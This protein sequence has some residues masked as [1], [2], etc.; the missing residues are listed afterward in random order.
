MRRKPKSSQLFIR[1]RIYMVLGSIAA[2]FLALVGRVAFI[3]VVD[4]KTLITQGDMR[5]VRTEKTQE[6]RG[7]IT[8]RNGNELAVSVAVRAV[9]ADPKRI[10]QTD[11]LAQTRKWK[12]LAE[13]LHL[14]PAELQQ[15][16]SNPKRRFV[17]L[18]RQVNPALG[19]FIQELN[20]P[21]VYLKP[22]S[23]RFYPAGEISAHLVGFT[24]IDDH[25]QEGVELAYDKW[26]TGQ[27]GERVVRK[28]RLGRTIEDLSVIKQQQSGHDIHLSLDQRI[29]T[30]A[31]REIKREVEASGATSGSVVVIDIH[32]G[33]VLAMA[34]SPSFNPNDRSQLQSYRYRNRAVTDAYEPGSTMKPFTVLTALEQ[35]KANRNTI[36]NNNPG[37]ISISGHKV[38]D[39]EVLG[40]MTL[41]KILERS[42]NIG[43][44]TLA[45]RTG[46]MPLLHTY[47][48]V[49]FGN[50]LGLGLDGETTGVIPQRRRWSD[51]ELATIAFG[52]GLTVSPLQLAHAYA[53]LGSGGINRPVS[54]LKVDTPPEGKRVFSE[55]NARMV[56]KM[57]E[58]VVSDDGTGSKAQVP[59]Y[60]VAGKTGTSRKAHA[61]G[62]SDN[63]VALFAGVA[64]VT[65][66]RLAISVVINNPQGDHY[67][68]GQ[69]AAPVFAK[70][71]SGSLRYLNIPP[72]GNGIHL[73]SL[74]ESSES[75][76][77]G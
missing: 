67:Y 28:D 55:K 75:N 56:L 40:N 36:I 45:I 11:S 71:M 26:L 2:V 24:N 9:W 7:M 76:N 50:V 27:S 19:H 62:Y 51:F 54:I 20:L 21:G 15:R 63:Y 69:V 12:A 49:G 37:Y 57:L 47:Y 42:S 43:A 31:Y 61:G 68:G 30:L 10:A 4:S 41:T 72:D 53:T 25:G 48:D 65:H 60:Q 5:S 74:D 16:I 59:G 13:A 1:W 46:V 34:N 44:A 6:Q 73:V 8:D 14:D 38:R 66:P 17:Y 33:E 35:G 64:P 77:E 39:D 70:V 22:E 29:Q 52:Y 32:T 3:Q 23:R 58:S 18:K